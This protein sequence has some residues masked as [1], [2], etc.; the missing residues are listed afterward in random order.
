MI[1]AVS[2]K[3]YILKRVLKGCAYISLTNSLFALADC[4]D[5]LFSNIR[6]QRI[7]MIIIIYFNITEMVLSVIILEILLLYKT[8]VHILKVNLLEYHII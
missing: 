7:I 1:H 5:R 3:E 2:I 4:F 8:F 6:I